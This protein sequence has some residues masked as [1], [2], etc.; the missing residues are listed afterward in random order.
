MASMAS[1]SSDDMSC[2]DERKKGDSPSETD[3][4]TSST[5]ESNDSRG[6]RLKQKRKATQENYFQG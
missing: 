5:D 4:S 3:T 6:H 2:C 1:D